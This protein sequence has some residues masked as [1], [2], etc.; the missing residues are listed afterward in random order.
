LESRSSG[1]ARLWEKVG[2][3][4]KHRGPPGHFQRDNARD[5]RIT[6]QN[7]IAV[8]SVNVSFTAAPD[9]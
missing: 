6:A 5:A 4:N 9:Y 7:D 2:L 1:R 3:T 8:V